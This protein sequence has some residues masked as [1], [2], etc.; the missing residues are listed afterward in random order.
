LHHACKSHTCFHECELV[1]HT[2]PAEKETSQNM[3][4]ELCMPEFHISL[5]KKL[6]VPATVN[7]HD[8]NTLCQCVSFLQLAGAASTAIMTGCTHMCFTATLHRPH[9]CNM[10][11]ASHLLPYPKGMNAFHVKGA[12]CS[13]PGWIC[14]SGRNS[15][16][17]GQIE[18]S[19]M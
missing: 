11:S 5:V 7:V 12:S 18:G 8:S 14:L 16:A 15:S 19:R 9:I 10:S 17:R 3:Q 4:A 13:L 2:H 1:A 6:H